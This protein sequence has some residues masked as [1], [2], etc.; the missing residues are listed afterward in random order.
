MIVR[1]L[2]QRWERCWA[3]TSSSSPSGMGPVSVEARMVRWFFLG[4]IWATLAGLV[5]A[6]LTQQLDLLRGSARGQAYPTT[7]YTPMT[8]PRMPSDDGA[9]DVAGADFAQVYT[10][11]LALRSGQS[12]YRPTSREFLDR[13]GRPSGYPPLTNWVYVPLSYLSYRHALFA[14][15]AL[16]LLFLFGVTAL[17][18]YQAKLR[19]HIGY[20]LAAQAALVFLT[21]IGATHLERGQFDL[22][23]A[24]GTALCFACSFVAKKSLLP[25]ALITGFV[26]ALKW[27]GAVFFGCFSALGFLLSSGMRRWA[28][29]VIPPVM[30]VGTL[31]FWKGVEEYWLT[32]RVYELEAAPFGLTMQYFLPRAPAKAM[33]VAITLALAAV[34]LAKARTAA[35]RAHLLRVTGAPFALALTNLGVCFGTLSYEYH[36]ITTLGMLP[37]FAVWLEQAGVDRHV[38]RG[39]TVAYGVFLTVV[40]HLLDRIVVLGPKAMSAV[41]VAFAALFFGISLLTAFASRLDGELDGAFSG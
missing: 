19:H 2:A 37:G 28:F 25:F 7:I 32:I 20:A 22:L 15:T 36:T 17:V 3:A 13:F 10:S 33:P 35:Q 12:A 21:P 4:L 16:S 26:G 6:A 34:V 39:T 9:P 1:L 18:L 11:A 29:F 30:L 27:T 31:S 23:V 38:K 5:L 8:V 40:F 24:A 14:H 41:Y